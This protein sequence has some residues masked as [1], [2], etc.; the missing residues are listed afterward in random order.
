M[1]ENMVF[2]F[3]S[4]GVIAGLAVI[5]I[6]IIHWVWWELTKDKRRRK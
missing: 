5:A 6:A 2:Q 1:E 4:I 3:L